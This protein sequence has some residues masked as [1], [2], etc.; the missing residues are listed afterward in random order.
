MGGDRASNPVKPVTP[1]YTSHTCHGNSRSTGAMLL[2]TT[3]K[4]TKLTFSVDWNESPKWWVWKRMVL[5]NP[6][7][8][9]IRKWGGTRFL[10]SLSLAIRKHLCPSKWWSGSAASWCRRAAAWEWA[11]ELLTFWDDHFQEANMEVSINGECTKWMVGKILL[12]WMTCGCPH[13]RN[14]HM[15]SLKR[16]LPTGLKGFLEIFRLQDKSANQGSKTDLSENGGGMAIL[17]L[18]YTVY[19]WSELLFFWGVLA[20]EA[21]QCIPTWG[22]WTW[23]LPSNYS[24]TVWESQ[25]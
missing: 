20:H 16:N 1:H 22:F 13:F 21:S 3:S 10:S 14:L 25:Q 19:A 2:L 17:W 9:F 18:F 5:E 7:I 15:L 12:K 23:E 24:Y 8:S 11:W 6:F 4:L